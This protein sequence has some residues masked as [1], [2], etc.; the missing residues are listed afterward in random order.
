[1]PRTDEVG[2]VVAVA[3]PSGGHGAAGE[4]D[5]VEGHVGPGHVLA[6]QVVVVPRGP[7]RRH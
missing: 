1:M 6:R 2:D 3:E 7:G 4:V 5:A